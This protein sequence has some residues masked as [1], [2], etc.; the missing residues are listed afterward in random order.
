MRLH[1]TLSWC[2]RSVRAADRIAMDQSAASGCQSG[3]GRA[4][5]PQVPRRALEGCAP[6]STAAAVSARS[7]GMCAR[8]GQCQLNP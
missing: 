1:H 2:R 3:Q 7:Q 8:S 5:T 4:V 6:I